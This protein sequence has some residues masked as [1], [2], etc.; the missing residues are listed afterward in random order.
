M[1][2]ILEENSEKRIKISIWIFSIAFLILTFH[3][4]IVTDVLPSF[5]YASLVY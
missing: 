1:E 2:E 5:F 3:I 4:A